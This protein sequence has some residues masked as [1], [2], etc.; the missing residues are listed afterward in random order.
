[1]MRAI[2][3]A[4]VV[5]IVA[6][7]LLSVISCPAQESRNVA[8]LSLG[9]R[10]LSAEQTLKDLQSQPEPRNIQLLRKVEKELKGLLESD[11]NT[12]LRLQVESDLEI[13]NESLAYHDLLVARF[14]L[15]K[16]HGHSLRGAEVR[17]THI[18]KA[19]PKFSKMDEVL[20]HLGLV[21]VAQEKPDEGLRVFSKLICRYPDSQH[22]KD[23]FAQLYQIGV[24]S[25]PGC[26]EFK[27]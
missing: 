12:M 2:C 20:L 3:I 24:S 4:K 8:H 6:L 11:L 21:M 13:V 22:V 18:V 16:T 26:D 23:A 15:S 10:V 27:P 19:Y 17:L 14:Y 7:L 25:W 5:S 9:D 1:M